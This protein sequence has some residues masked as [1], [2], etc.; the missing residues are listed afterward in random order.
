MDLRLI[1]SL[2]FMAVFNE[3]SGC[4]RYHLGV[5]EYIFG[6]CAYLNVHQISELFFSVFIFSG[7]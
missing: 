7:F 6:K 1:P 3:I 4:S 2:D 5:Q